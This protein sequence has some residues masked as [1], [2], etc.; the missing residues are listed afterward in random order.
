TRVWQWL[1]L[2]SIASM[3]PLSSG[4][5]MNRMLFASF[6]GASVC[7]SFVICRN[8][9]KE[10]LTFRLYRRYFILIFLM[11]TPLYWP[12]MSFNSLFTGAKTRAAFL[13]RPELQGKDLFVFSG[14]VPTVRF[15]T[16]IQ[17]YYQQP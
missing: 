6:L 17:D 11:V 9:K 13:D 2:S 8:T 7:I 10:G 4:F 12:F 3:I 14:F 15:M 1:F 16:A 5:P